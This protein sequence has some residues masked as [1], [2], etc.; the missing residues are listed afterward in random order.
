MIATVRLEY[1]WLPLSVGVGWAGSPGLVVPSASLHFGKG[2]RTR[3]SVLGGGEGVGGGGG[4]R[5]SWVQGEP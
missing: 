5:M 1:R 3:V 2:I 4:G